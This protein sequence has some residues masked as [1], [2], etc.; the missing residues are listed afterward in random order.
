LFQYRFEHSTFPGAKKQLF[1]KSG[2]AEAKNV[3]LRR[4]SKKEAIRL[5]RYIFYK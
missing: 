5:R 1:L 4:F 2:F 3:L